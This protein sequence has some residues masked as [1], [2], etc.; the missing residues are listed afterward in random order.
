MD[1]VIIGAGVAGMQAAFSCRQHW[2]QKTVTLIDAEAEVGYFRTL[3]P[4]FMVRTLAQSKL[5]FWKP[6]DD[7]LL[8]VRPGLRAASLDRS[9]QR[10]LLQNGEKIAYERLILASG[11]RP[12]IP[13]M[14]ARSSCNGIFPIRYLTSAREVQKWLPGI[15]KSLSSAAAWLG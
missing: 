14:C 6:E 7:P 10:V 4:Q 3:L 11:G 8:V 12:I 9:N 2:P 13:G 5:F 15:P 1:C